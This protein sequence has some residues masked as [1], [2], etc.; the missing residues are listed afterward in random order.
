MPHGYCYLWDPRMVWLHVISDGLITLSY[1]CIPVVLIYFIRKNRDIPFNRIFWMFG[2][3]ILACGT[4]HLLEIWNVWHGSYLLAGVV[5]GITA[6]VS[7]LTAAMLIPLVPRV[8]SIPGRIHLQE[9]NRKLVRDITERERVEEARGRLAA[10]VESSDDAIMSKTPDGTITS[11]NSA[12]EKLFGYSRSEAVGK[13][14][15]MLLPKELANE[16]ADILARIRRGESVDHFETVRVRKDGTEIDVSVTISPIKDSSGTILGASK[17]VR[18]ITERKRAERAIRHSLATSEIA[19]KELA[20][21]KFALDQH[22]IVAVTD[23]QG[24]ITY[25]NDKFCSISQYSKYELIGQNHRILN[26]GHHPQEFFQEMYH[27]I[28]KG[29]VWHGEIK[30]RAK[31]GSIYWVDTTIVPFVDENGK[32]RQYVAIRADITERK[33]AEE[34]LR[35]SDE[36]FQTMA[37]SIPQLAWMAEADGSIFW[38]N[39]RWHEYTGTTLEQ[40]QGWGWQSVHDPAVLPMVLERW[41]KSIATGTPFDMEFPLRGTDGRLCMFL[42]RIMPVKDSQGRVVRWFGTNTDISERKETEEQLARQAGVLSQQA[43]ELSR[44]RQE[45]ETQTLMLQSVL[46][47]MA[48][49]LVAADEQGKFLIWNRAAERI[50]GYGPADLRIQEWSA[51]YGQYLPD[52]VTPLPAE[53]NPLARAIRGE[54]CSAQIFLRNPKVAGGVWIEANA[55]PLRNTAGAVRGG[56]VA[57]RDITQR[58][59]DERVIRELNDDLELRVVN[60]TA[61]LETANKELEAFSYSVSHDLRAPLRHIG[62]FSKLLVEEF[63]SNLDANARHY[64]ERIQS[65]TQKMGLLVDE[66]LNLARVGR[67]TLSLRPTSLNSIVAE[68]IAILQPE[69]QGRQVEWAIADLPAV[70]CDPVLVKQVF[71]NLL[72]NALKFTRPRVSAGGNARAETPAPTRAVVEVSYRANDGQPEFVVRDNGIGFNMKYVDKLFGV[73]QRLHSADEFEGTGIGLATVQRIVQ[74]HGGRVWAEGELDKGAAFYFTL[75]AGKQ[76]ESKR[77]GAAAGGRL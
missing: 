44:S 71:Q 32:P 3:F 62:G 25:V 47:S 22:A 46:D 68:V 51:H 21:Q 73:F 65:G 40:M 69:S 5:K 11:W 38:Y 75:S 15:L 48:E 53:Q 6:A 43:Q 8:I 61:Q 59:A 18:D 26:S 34:K 60:R 64:V 14:M 70:D 20:D 45:L 29:K 17:I 36:R 63:G 4:T 39:Q 12:A 16:E 67:H 77:N 72:A 30:N 56:V 52:G 1:Y 55:S 23:V 66:L 24:T 57:F 19:L 42:T 13:P 35:E 33:Q 74:K 37:N 7:V 49:G 54:A 58:V 27:T 76:T 2:T 50:V 10:V 9:K 31:D 28:A 41:K